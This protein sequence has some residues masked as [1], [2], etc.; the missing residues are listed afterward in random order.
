MPSR[1]RPIVA[2]SL[3]AIQRVTAAFKLSPLPDDEWAEL[4]SLLVGDTSDQEVV[5]A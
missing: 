4:L 5:A 1:E 3:S 2:T